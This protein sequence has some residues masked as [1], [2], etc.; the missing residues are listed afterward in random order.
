M[1]LG[2]LT[3]NNATA[4]FKEWGY[5]LPCGQGLL[6]LGSKFLPRPSLKTAP[7]VRA[8]SY[9]AYLPTPKLE[10]GLALFGLLWRYTVTKSRGRDFEMSFLITSEIIQHS[11][12]EKFGKP[13]NLHST[14][15]E[16][17]KKILTRTGHNLKRSRRRDDSRM[18][19]VQ[20][21]RVV[22]LETCRWRHSRCAGVTSCGEGHQITVV[23]SAYNTES[24]ECKVKQFF[25]CSWSY[26][27]RQQMR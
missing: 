16:G 9:F 13:P 27:S 21:P 20:R 23:K 5:I 22:E 18:R 26:L 15:T 3:Y 11:N 17:E 24:E 10:S 6:H 8:A 2:T 12:I 19:L 25:A 1:P 7:W 4:G 14:S